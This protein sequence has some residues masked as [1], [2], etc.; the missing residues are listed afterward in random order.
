MFEDAFDLLEEGRAIRSA[1]NES[2]KSKIV[3]KDLASNGE[4]FYKTNEVG[5]WICEKIQITFYKRAIRRAIRN[6]KINETVKQ[7]PKTILAMFLPLYFSGFFLILD[8]LTTLKIKERPT[9]IPKVKGERIK[10]I[11]LATLNGS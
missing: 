5:K 4:K 1:V 10:A 7:M 6:T 3:T 11:K 2:L 9:P 8:K